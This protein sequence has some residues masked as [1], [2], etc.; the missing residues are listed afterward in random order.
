M[1]VKFS[2]VDNGA[3]NRNRPYVE[4]NV[5]GVKV[6]WSIKTGWL[7][8]DHGTSDECECAFMVMEHL[9]RRILDRMA[10]LEMTGQAPS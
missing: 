2:T 7:C 1:T 3:R 6:R 10:H 8:A 9:S 4:A 5:D